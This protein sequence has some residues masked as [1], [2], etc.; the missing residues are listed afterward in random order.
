MTLQ[1]TDQYGREQKEQGQQD[2][3]VKTFEDMPLKHYRDVCQNPYVKKAPDE[4]S[5]LR[6]PK[7]DGQEQQRLKWRVDVVLANASGIANL[8]LLLSVEVVKLVPVSFAYHP[9]GGVAIREIGSLL[10][11]CKIVREIVDKA[12]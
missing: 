2:A 10:S 7:A 12:G 6:G 5:G 3:P 4:I 1:K 8:E 11:F 9:S